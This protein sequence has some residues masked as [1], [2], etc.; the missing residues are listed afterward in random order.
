MEPKSASEMESFW[1][2]PVAQNAVFPTVSAPERSLAGSPK[3]LQKGTQKGAKMEPEM[4]QNGGKSRVA[5]R[6]ILL[7]IL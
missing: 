6:Q 4:E 1:E 5:D 2:P 3:V 7:S